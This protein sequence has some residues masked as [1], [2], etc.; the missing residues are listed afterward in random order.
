ML[1]ISICL[2][3]FVGT[4]GFALLP[5]G[6]FGILSPLFYVCFSDSRNS[7]IYYDTM[8]EIDSETM[9]VHKMA[10]T[11]SNAKYINI[12]N[13]S[14]NVD[15][16]K[17]IGKNVQA[18]NEKP[19]TPPNPK[20]NRV[21]LVEKLIPTKVEPPKPN[22]IQPGFNPI[23][24]QDPRLTVDNNTPIQ[25][26]RF[27]QP[28]NQVPFP[29]PGNQVPFPMQGNQV[30]FPMQGQPSMNNQ[31]PFMNPNQGPFNFPAKNPNSPFGQSDLPIH[32]LNIGGGNNQMDYGNNL[33]TVP[34]NV[35][36]DHGDGKKK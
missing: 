22:P 11:F 16:L 36:D 25:H 18:I 31:G 29:M 2:L 35:I 20:S 19:K 28:G 9:G 14:T 13:I 6:I 30:P 17:R 10:G 8:T 23:P 5:F 12:I 4:I 3:R 24:N 33:Y 26:N 1:A 32:E 15:R 27:S 21:I 7:K 34:T